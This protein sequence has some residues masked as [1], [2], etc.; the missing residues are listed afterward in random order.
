MTCC[1]PRQDSN[2][3]NVIRQCYTS[4]QRSADSG[5]AEATT[6]LYKLLTLAFPSPRIQNN[7]VITQPKGESGVNRGI[8]QERS[9][10]CTPRHSV[11]I[12]ILFTL[13]LPSLI[14]TG[15]E[16]TGTWT[17]RLENP[18]HGIA[19]QNTLTLTLDGERVAG[20]FG[21]FDVKGV[22]KEGR[23]D[24]DFP[25]ET[26]AGAKASLRINGAMINDTLI[27]EWSCTAI[28]SGT[29][30]ATTIPLAPRLYRIGGGVSDPVPIYKPEPNY[31]EEARK[32][33]L[34]GA[35][36]LQIVIDEN[37]S[38]RD[39][40]VLRSLG[41]GLN[42]KAVEAVLMWRFRPAV[43]EGKAVAV[44]ANVE[45]NFRLLNDP[46]KEQQAGQ[47]TDPSSRI[48]DLLRHSDI[49]AADTA[50]QKALVSAPGS[51]TVHAV[52]GDVYF[53]KGQFAHAAEEYAK[54]VKLDTRCARCIWG[55]G[56]IYECSSRHATAARLFVTAHDIDPNDPDILYD[57]AGT[58]ATA[59]E[60]MEA[61]QRFW[62]S[63]NFAYPRG[64]A[65]EWTQ[66]LRVLGDTPTNVLKSEPVNQR[67]PLSYLKKDAGVSQWFSIPVSIN[68][69]KPENL[70]LDTTQTGI[71]IS[72]TFADKSG[73]TKLFKRNIG[74][75]E[76]SYGLVNSVRIG[77]VE[78]E[79]CL[80]QMIEKEKFFDYAGV[81]GTD[82]FKK[83]LVTIEFRDRVLR[84]EPLPRIPPGFHDR[85]IGPD[86]KNFSPVLV[87]GSSLIVPTSVNNGDPVLF[88]IATCAFQ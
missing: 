86:R 3:L 48:R 73:L 47:T 71:L 65:M 58:R 46:V 77:G 50:L 87:F 25:Y 81:V 45:V 31:A 2:L 20:K 66:R 8:A 62:Q 12:R 78:F 39:V 82:I 16:L 74:S 26:P 56:R 59:A 22:Y 17:L 55:L 72:R 34:E 51:P 24:L 28:G 83:F 84:L 33:R 29:F 5:P 76:G 64:G 53:R 27:G 1:T 9:L 38:V 15:T 23:L 10:E 54:A 30:K 6:R 37:G 60:Q 32:A 36:L 49:D 80:V 70:I 21:R 52:A 41:L 44:Q 18:D 4:D 42:E 63:A 75:I 85:T 68:G 88:Q 79:N 11:F 61:L 14:I 69:G 43:K 57:W 7:L 13:L 67:I 19:L 35:V 40:K